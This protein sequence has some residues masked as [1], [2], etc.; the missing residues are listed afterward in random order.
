MIA[1]VD[2]DAGN[3]KSVEKA[4]GFLD[5]PVKVTKDYDEIMNASHL[6]LPGVG[7]FGDAVENLRAN[8][9]DVA[10]L[11]FI[12]TKKPFLGICIGM[13]LLFEESEESPGVL[14]L[15]IIKGKIKKFPQKEGFKVP[16]M[17]WNTIS[18]KGRLF[19]GIVNNPYVYFVH[20]YYADATDGGV[21][22]AKC[23]YIVD[24]AAAVEADNIF[25]V[26]FHPEKSSDVGLKILENFLKL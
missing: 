15:G 13:Q 26:Q 14:G 3:L 19:E 9:L 20:S 5:R 7:H 1:V 10:I 17:G 11:D 21:V 22:S 12:K 18:A 4:I 2:Y 6:I 24:F 16:H 25:A 8:N 23:S